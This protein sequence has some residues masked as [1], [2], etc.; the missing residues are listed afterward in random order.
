MTAMALKR[1]RW[2]AGV[3][4]AR[5]PGH[6]GGEDMCVSTRAHAGTKEGEAADRT[7]EE[8]DSQGTTG[9]GEP[10]RASTLGRRLTA[11]SESEL[12]LISEAEFAEERRAARPRRAGRGRGGAHGSG[13]IF[14]KSPTDMPATRGCGGPMNFLA[15][16]EEAGWEKAGTPETREG[17]PNA[18]RDRVATG[19]PG[20]RGEEG[21]RGGCPGNGAI[22]E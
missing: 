18:E 7:T 15:G 19:P 1:M 16:T 6:G 20:E 5:S 10:A 21:G 4:P 22:A 2:P 12:P 9:C 17:T 8:G 13:P 3:A 14:N 11:P